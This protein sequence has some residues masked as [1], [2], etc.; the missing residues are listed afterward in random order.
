M[1]WYIYIVQQLVSHIYMRVFIQ[2]N[3]YFIIHNIYFIRKTKSIINH[4][5][6][7]I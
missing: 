7:R 2:T 4:K 1:Q 3:I 5:V 6:F